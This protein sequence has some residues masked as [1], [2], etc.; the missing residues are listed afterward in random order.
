M[1]KCTRWDR[2]A[3]GLNGG[4]KYREVFKA[5][6]RA[7]QSTVA[8]KRMSL[9]RATEGFPIAA[10]REVKLLSQL[11][12]RNIVTLR[13]VSTAKYAPPEL[14]CNA[15]RLSA[16]FSYP[17]NFFMVCDY[18]EHSL[19]GL[20]DRGIRF[21]GP[22]VKQLMKQICQGLAFIHSQHVMHRDVKCSNILL[23]A[24]GVVKLADFGMG[25]RFEPNVAL[26]PSK[27]VVTRWYR[28]PEL[29]LGG[30]YTEAIDMWAAGCVFA[31]LLTG[32]ALFKG[33]TEAEQLARI[34][35]LLGWPTDTFWPGVSRFPEYRSMHTA[36]HV[37][38]SDCPTGLRA[39]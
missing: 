22:Q 13:D 27:T 31:E 18:A 4:F 16:P 34:V 29:L 32:D 7:D 3:T 2:A 17:W 14:L 21:T 19:K 10:L 15:Q 25:T 12:H 1:R 24:Q 6:R 28:A 8:I 37:S 5:V 35:A 39:T 23:N 26:N 20:L 38:V 30:P 36:C 9:E 33:Q 11:R